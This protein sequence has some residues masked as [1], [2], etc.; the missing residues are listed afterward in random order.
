MSLG[1][2]LELNSEAKAGGFFAKKGN[3]CFS[4]KKNYIK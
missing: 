1:Q 3:F 4:L 2:H